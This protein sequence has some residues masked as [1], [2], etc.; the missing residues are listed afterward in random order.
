M[1]RPGDIVKAV[2]KNIV[3]KEPQSY[4]EPPD[5]LT[6]GRGLVYNCKGKHWACVDKEDYFRCKDNETWLKKNNKKTECH[7]LNVY[8]SSND[9]KIMQLHKIHSLEKITFCSK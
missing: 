3:R 9:C 4:V 7:V 8:S 1:A 6:R 5:Y 2:N